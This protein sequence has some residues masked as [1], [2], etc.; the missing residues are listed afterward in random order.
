MNNRLC[1]Y[2]LLPLVAVVVV[3]V[4]YYGLFVYFAFEQHVACSITQAT[5]IPYGTISSISL[6]L[7]CV[8]ML[9]ISITK[10]SH[11]T[12]SCL[13]TTYTACQERTSQEK[14]DPAE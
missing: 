6:L 7:F 10:M 4:A 2:A 12:L 11:C 5:N 13:R 1:A 3:P 9:A 8:V 14:K